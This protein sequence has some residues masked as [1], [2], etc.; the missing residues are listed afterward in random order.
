MRSFIKIQDGCDYN[1]SFC[2]IPLA[3]GKSR[4]ASIEDV[5]A[6]VNKIANEGFNEIV[7][8]GINLGD[9]GAGGDYNFLDLINELEKV[10]LENKNIYLFDSF[11]VF[12][13]QKECFFSDENYLLYADKDHISNYAARYIY[14]PKML[15][16]LQENQILDKKNK[17]LAKG[18][19]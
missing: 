4:S 2:T 3:R 12:C 16:F 14:A 1:C 6:R 19:I 11:K 17:P 13:P 9:F 15:E 10:S 18:G 5:V 8:S 7:L